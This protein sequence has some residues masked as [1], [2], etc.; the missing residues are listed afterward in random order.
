MNKKIKKY[1]DEIA[2]TEKKIADL[3][4]YLRGVQAALKQEE[5]NEMIRCI[6]GMKMDNDQL[7]DLL[8]GIQSGKVK[9]QVSRES[10]EEGSGS[11]VFTEEKKDEATNTNEVLPEDGTDQ[12][13]AFTTPGNGEV[14]DDITDDSTKEFLTVTTKNNNTFYIVIDRSATSQ[15]V[16]MLS[17]ID[18]NDLSEFLDKDSTATVVTPQP[19]KS[20]V[21]LDETNNEDVDKEA[22]VD[23]E[24]TASTK[25]NMGAMAT[26]LILALGGV[27]AYYYF[28]IYK[29]KKEEDEDD[30]PE[31]LETGGLEEVPDEE[32]SEDED[33]EENEK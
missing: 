21:V 26:I 7:Y 6:R 1:L 19:D 27:A 17:Q 9:F 4:Q 31:G 32:E 24:K 13:T 15:N 29:P 10:D 14:K 5:D 2:K 28:K 20:K 25:T 8:D 23:P 33:F 18:E 30:Q 22:T 16:Y 11:F 12:G 3:Q